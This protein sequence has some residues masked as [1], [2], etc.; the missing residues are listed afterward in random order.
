MANQSNIL[1]VDITFSYTGT[2]N[3][4]TGFDSF[5]DWFATYSSDI[6]ATRFDSIFGV[7]HTDGEN[8]FIGN[9]DP[10]APIVLTRL[11]STK[12]L[13]TLSI[14]SSVDWNDQRLYGSPIYPGYPLIGYEYVSDKTFAMLYI[15]SSD[16]WKYATVSNTSGSYL[17][18]DVGNNGDIKNSKIRIEQDNWLQLIDGLENNGPA[19][20]DLV[21]DMDAYNISHPLGTLSY[22]LTTSVDSGQGSIT[23]PLG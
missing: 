16:L 1:S 9:E 12:S 17:G 6:S 10:Y 21:I 23:Q 4:A 3:P 7:K 14:H 2:W 22:C 20:L 19:K 8:V 5:A 18:V 13:T 15:K 11:S